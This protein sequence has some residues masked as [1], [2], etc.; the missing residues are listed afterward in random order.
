MA[1]FLK[2]SDV[3]RTAS[4]LKKLVAASDVNQDGAVRWQEARWGVD[5]TKGEGITAKRPTAGQKTILPS[6]AIEAVV[7]FSQAHGSSQ[8]PDLKKTIDELARRAKAADRDG[9]GFISDN[10]TRAMS[11][12]AEQAFVAFGKQYAHSNLTDFN[13]PQTH[14]GTLP[15]FSWT[16]T[17]EKVCS[18]LLNAFSDRKNDNFWPGGT[19]ASRFV[20]SNSEA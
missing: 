5:R 17:A 11:S 8:V 3:A 1:K 14:I 12:G 16:G 6:A 7:H 20:L 4:L 19:G 10:E 15:K 18:S 9:D 13:L 2:V